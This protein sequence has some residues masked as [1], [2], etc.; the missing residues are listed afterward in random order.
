MEINLG[1]VQGLSAYE[2]ALEKGFEGTEEEWLQSLGGKDGK[3]AYELA[4]EN[5]YE[6]TK[7]Q[8]LNS[9]KATYDDTELKNRMAE[10]ENSIGNID[11]I[12]DNINGEVV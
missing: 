4:V 3:S 5:G 11:T 12:L 10:I 1:R 2:I 7:E 6:G 9:L 8:W